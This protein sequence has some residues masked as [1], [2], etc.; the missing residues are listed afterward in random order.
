MGTEIKTWQI[1]DGRLELI[2]TSLA[3]AKR[4]EP[5]DLEE[6]IASNPDI[7]GTELSIIGRQVT[8]KSGPMDFL[9]IDKSGNLA[10]IELKRDKLPREALAQAIDYASDISSWSI[11]KIS[12]VCTKY[13]TR[14]LDESLSEAFPDIDIENIN[15]NENHGMGDGANKITQAIC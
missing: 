5:N 1:I 12:E 15:I 7:L 8:T 6:W 14:S 9:A 3:D 13:T 2:D 10:V 4:T 11:D